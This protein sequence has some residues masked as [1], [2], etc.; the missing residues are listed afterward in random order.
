MPSPGRRAQEYVTKWLNPMKFF[1]TMYLHACDFKYIAAGQQMVAIS[2][3]P[4]VDIAMK[5]KPKTKHL[6]SSR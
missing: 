4:E 2:F 5:L 6:F 3:V 1:I